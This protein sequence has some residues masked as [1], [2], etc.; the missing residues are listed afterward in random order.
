MDVCSVFGSAT[1]GFALTVC[2]VLVLPA[3]QL[4]KS[5]HQP[6]TPSPPR[7]ARYLRAILR[8]VIPL[9][10]LAID[11][12]WSARPLASLGLDFPVSP[13]GKLGLVV[14]VVLIAGLSLTA[15]LQMRRL[16]GATLAAYR[17][18]LADN[19]MFPHSTKELVVF[20]ILAL[21][22]GI[23]WEVLYRGFLLLVLTP[24]VGLTGAICTAALAYGIAHGY[25]S[26]WQFLGSIA[27]AFA[28]T[29]AYALTHSLWW[30][31][32][33]HVFMGVFGGSISYWILGKN[34][35]DS[36]RSFAERAVQPR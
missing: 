34:E 9:L 29:I 11:V 23:A 13:R 14:A 2:L 5:L 6:L 31:M 10:F 28:F 7:M 3:L 22:V 36:A 27:S 24:L 33:L 32:L 16:A 17:A 1:L 12:W 8:A 35:F 15:W 18:K 30:L 26:R 21:V 25:K 4:R 19:D 20:V